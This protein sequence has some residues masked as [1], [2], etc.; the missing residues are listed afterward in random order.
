MQ[1]FSLLEVHFLTP[2]LA[3]N[4]FLD[5][6]F[7]FTLSPAKNA[8]FNSTLHDSTTTEFQN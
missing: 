1:K 5:R 6:G 4:Y 2:K 3:G 8:T 7:H